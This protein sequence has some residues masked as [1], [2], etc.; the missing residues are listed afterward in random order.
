MVYFVYLVYLTHVIELWENCFLL[1]EPW[2]SAIVM[3]RNLG[4]ISLQANRGEQLSGSGQ[5]DSID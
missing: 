2:R 5:K 1:F 3:L 4:K